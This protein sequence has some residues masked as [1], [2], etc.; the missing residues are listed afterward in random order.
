MSENKGL[1]KIVYAKF[2]KIANIF[3]SGPIV[4]LMAL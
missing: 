3:E 4:G 1:R 2:V